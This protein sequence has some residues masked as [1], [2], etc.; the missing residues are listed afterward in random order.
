MKKY[1]S[2][3][4]EWLLLLCISSFFVFAASCSNKGSSDKSGQQTAT[5][6]LKQA[7]GNED[8]A[9][10]PAEAMERIPLQTFKIHTGKHEIVEALQG[11]KLLIPA[12]SFEDAN[13]QPVSGEVQIE[14]KEVNRP[15][16][17]LKG[18]MTTLSDGRLLE[19]DG[20]YF[21]NASS[22]GK[23]LRLRKNSKVYMSAPH[24]EGISGM[25]FFKGVKSESGRINWKEDP[26]NVNLDPKK[27]PV[28]A[29]ENKVAYTDEDKKLFD[30][31]NK[32]LHDVQNKLN[33]VSYLLPI[34]TSYLNDNIYNR[35]IAYKIKTLEVED[36]VKKSYYMPLEMLTNQ[37]MLERHKYTCYDDNL[38]FIRQKANKSVDTIY[39]YTKPA[40][41]VKNSN[42][43]GR[44]L[45]QKDFHVYSADSVNLRVEKVKG[46]NKMIPELEQRRK[47]ANKK[48]LALG[49][50]WS[51]MWQYFANELSRKISME[52]QEKLAKKRADYVQKM[53]QTAPYL[54]QLESTYFG[55]NDPSVGWM[56]LDRL[57]HSYPI[58]A[59]KGKL[60]DEAEIHVLSTEYMVHLISTKQGGS[61]Y[62]NGIELKE[63]EFT[64]K[65][66]DG[67]PFEMILIRPGRKEEILKFNGRSQDLGSI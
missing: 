19:S 28:L 34:Y 24:R 23:N 43:R 50:D 41:D 27:T 56:N 55:I 25:A 6:S 48:I 64:F 59:F 7:I 3:V 8:Y 51:K 2:Q 31:I 47:N 5:D 4:Q 17:Y 15:E 37:E 32:E 65:Y 61:G 39:Y 66:G 21:I 1:P 52:E 58:V 11:L 13:G 49:K 63:E 45:T 22:K 36:G 67:A 18:G 35:D 12:N 54:L 53:T 60:K 30:E 26:K 42:K 40:W 46:L 57:Y 10:S 20:C 14:V 33:M 62:S 44:E 38:F 29:N 9:L 16:D